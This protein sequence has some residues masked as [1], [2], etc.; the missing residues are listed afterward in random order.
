MG[1][2]DTDDV[3]RVAAV[4]LTRDGHAG[5]GYTLT[6]PEALTSGEQVQILADVLGRTIDFVD[7]TPAQLA[8]DSIEQGTPAETA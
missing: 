3:A 6:G 5:H 8:S 7:T 4:A 2:V 1:F